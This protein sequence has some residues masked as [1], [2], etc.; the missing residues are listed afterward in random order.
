[1][2]FVKRRTTGLGE[3]RPRVRVVR[4]FKKFLVGFAAAFAGLFALGPAHAE[5]I[6]SA[7]AAAY[8]Y[9]PI[10]EAERAGLRAIDE[11]VPQALAGRRPTITGSADAGYEHQESRSRPGGVGPTATSFDL[12]PRGYSITLSQPIFRGFQVVNNIRQAEALVKAG[13]QSLY[14]TEQNTLFDAAE[15][16]MDVVRDIA[17]VEIRRNNVRILKEQLRATLDRFNVGEVTRTDVAQGE[18]RV[19]LAESGLSLA[20]ANLASSRAIYEQVIGHPPNGVQQPAAIDGMLPNDLNSAIAIAESEHPAILA[21]SFA[22]EAA[23]HAV[24]ARRGEQLPTVDL[25]AT[26]S[27]RYDTSGFTRRSESASITGRLNVPLFQRG[28][29]ASRIRESRQTLLQR[30]LEVEQARYQVRAAVASAWSQL[31]SIKAQ[32]ESDRAQVRANQV[33]LNGVREEAK[34]GQRTT[35]DVLD[36]EQEY[37][38]AQVTL[39]GTLRDRVIATYAI[40]SAIG[41]LSSR[42]LALGVEEYNPTANYDNVRNRIFGTGISN[43][44]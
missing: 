29:V 16:Y 28:E 1:M 10:L 21:A 15:A 34:V 27:N 39:V 33:A 20:Q 6:R 5:D 7:M 38:N 18:A 17:I 3:V 35:L 14:N 12:R 31:Q 44:D 26:F 9:N 40:L 32:L 42:Q 8:E 25:E 23:S 24:N 41:R 22:A 37:L 2:R 11:G 30:Q 4:H 43:G 19:A 36:A 13:R